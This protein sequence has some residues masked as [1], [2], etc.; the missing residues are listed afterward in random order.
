MCIERPI[1]IY[2]IANRNALFTIARASWLA[3]TVWSFAY[4]PFVQSLTDCPFHLDF[5]SSSVDQPLANR[6]GPAAG[7]PEWHLG[8]GLLLNPSRGAEAHSWV[9]LLSAHSHAHTLLK[10]AYARS[11]FYPAIRFPVFVA[12]GQHLIK[13]EAQL[14]LTNLR[15]AFIGQ[16]RSSDIVPF[17]ILLLGSFLFCNSNFV[18]KTRRFHDI[19]LQKCRDLEIVVRGHSRSLKMVPFGRSGMVFYSLVTL[20]LKCIVFEIFDM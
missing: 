20:S 2:R 6:R 12:F 19:R 14:M 16:S 15:D 3:K 10:I 4:C 7:I 11:H 5:V 9:I 13:H 1:F 18:F 17:H 8:V